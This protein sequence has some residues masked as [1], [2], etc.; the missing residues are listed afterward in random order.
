MPPIKR[1][2]F[3]IDWHCFGKHSR[4]RNNLTC[5]ICDIEGPCIDE[6]S[7]NEHM[8]KAEQVKNQKPQPLNNPSSKPTKLP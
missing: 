6:T 7:F 4:S 1:E 8:K 2:P 5:D 3:T